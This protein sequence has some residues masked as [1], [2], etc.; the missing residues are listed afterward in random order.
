MNVRVIEIRGV[1]Y[2]RAE[3]VARLLRE[4]GAT[5]ATDV[6]DRLNEMANNLD[7]ALAKPL[8]RKSGEGT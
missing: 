6:C 4:L 3:D 2:L 8:S 5:E 7:A 1:K